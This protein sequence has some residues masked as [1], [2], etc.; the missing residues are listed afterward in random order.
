MD[1]ACP[2][3]LAAAR[4]LVW[5][6]DRSD[7]L[8]PSA[9][10]SSV[11]GIACNVAG[12]NRD[13]A[14]IHLAARLAATAPAYVGTPRALID[15]SLTAAHFGEFDVAA[16][17]VGTGAD[18]YS[19]FGA[20]G[21]SCD[22][23]IDSVETAQQFEVA[24]SSHHRT[25]ALRQLAAPVPDWDA[26]D[27][28]IRRALEACQEADRRLKDLDGIDDTWN[29]FGPG[30][31]RH[32]GD[33]TAQWPVRPAMRQAELF[34]LMEA[35]VALG[36]RPNGTLTRIRK[37]S[38]RSVVALE[39]IPVD[40]GLPDYSNLAS[41]R[42]RLGIAL[43]RDDG[44]SFD[45]ALAGIDLC[46]IGFAGVSFDTNDEL[47]RLNGLARLRV[48]GSADSPGSGAP[49]DEPAGNDVYKVCNLAFVGPGC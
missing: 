13:R 43:L 10:A 44:A 6:L 48:S 26:F 36:H 40:P 3:A 28:S 1:R 25:Q 29:G 45:D 2:A 23:R 42:I 24:R 15:A 27:H 30:A 16:A 14:A 21:G 31:D 22:P 17:A 8:V 19:Q 4:L 38:D 33:A 46:Q 18:L 41:T 34:G 20:S 5:A 35:A 49:V 32:G 39:A 12:Y 11:L 9:T 47:R 7:T 37:G